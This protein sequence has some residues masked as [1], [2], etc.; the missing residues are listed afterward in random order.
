M[1]VAG[2]DRTVD[3]KFFDELLASRNLSL[4]TLGPKMGR[5]HSQLS[6]ILS[7]QRRMQLEE[8]VRLAEIFNV[9][10]ARIAEAAGYGRAPSQGDDCPE[11]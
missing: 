8:A 4:R 7:G 2:A 5:T 11:I 9:P 10:L 1:T 3:R 6:L